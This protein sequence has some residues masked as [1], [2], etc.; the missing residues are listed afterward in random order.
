MCKEHN[1]AGP[2]SSSNSSC[3]SQT[4]FVVL[5]GAYVVD[6]RGLHELGAVSTMLLTTQKPPRAQGKSDSSS[7]AGVSCEDEHPPRAPLSSVTALL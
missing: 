7:Q 5:C 2:Q 3:N 6:D 4:S 1:V